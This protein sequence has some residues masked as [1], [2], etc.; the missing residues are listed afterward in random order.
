[1]LAGTR[2]RR[3]RGGGRL[4]GVQVQAGEDAVHVG[5]H[6]L[7]LLVVALVGGVVVGAVA[8]PDDRPARGSGRAAVSSATQHPDTT[9]AGAMASAGCKTAVDRANLTLTSAVRLQVAVAKQGRILRDPA[10]RKLSGRQVLQKVAPWLRASS[11][12]SARFKSCP[13]RLPPGGGP[14]HAASILSQAGR[15]ALDGG[16][17]DHV[18]P[19][20]SA[21]V[22]ELAAAGHQ[23]QRRGQGGVVHVIGGEPALVVLLDPLDDEPDR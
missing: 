18:G 14:V 7:G 20:V 4:G 3:G 15:S 22:V 8:W 23:P 2:G 1:M 12:E 9:A 10:N 11:G 6:R 13:G 17:D 19:V 16:E 21:G 5:L